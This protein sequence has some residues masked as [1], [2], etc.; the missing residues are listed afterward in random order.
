M[1]YGKFTYVVQKQQIVQPT[2][3]W[4]VNNVGYDRLV[5][6]ACNPIY[7]ASQRIIVFAK[8]RSVTPAGAS[9]RGRLVATSRRG[10]APRSRRRTRRSLEPEIVQV[11]RSRFTGRTCTPVQLEPAESLIVVTDA[12][13]NWLGRATT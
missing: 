7:S 9:P 12:A 10:R 8:L 11:T 2:D 13:E 1:P 6:S 5:L 3:V 4:V